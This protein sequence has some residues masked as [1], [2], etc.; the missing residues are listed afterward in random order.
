MPEYVN[1]LRRRNESKN[2]EGCCALP[3]GGG[4]Q[5]HSRVLKLILTTP[6]KRSS[7][8]LARGKITNEKTFFLEPV[9][10]HPVCVVSQVVQTLT[11]SRAKLG[12]KMAGTFRSSGNAISAR[13]LRSGL[14]RDLE[15]A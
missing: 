15:P 9:D 11:D 12:L 6:L 4:V 1:R 3:H 7:A 13:F 8:C 14:V 2:S 5:R 10:V